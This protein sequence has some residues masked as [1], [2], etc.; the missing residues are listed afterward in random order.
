M[1]L[2]VLHSVT[3]R[4]SSARH[5][6][7][8]LDE[9]SL[10]I[11]QGELVA[12]WGV[13]RSGRSTLLRVAAGIEPPDEGVVTFAGRE[14]GSRGGAVLG[15]QVGYVNTNF[16][17]TQGGSV[18]DHVA[19]GLMASGLSLDQARSR[20][21]RALDRVGVANCADLDP[22]TLDPAEQVRVGLARALVFT[23]RLLLVDDPANGVGVLQRESILALVRSIADEGIAVLMTV[24]EVVTIADRVLTIDDG[25][26]RG[27]VAPEGARVLQLR[28]AH[29][30]P[31]A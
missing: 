28:P 1:P 9:V 7:I 26:L 4:Y 8:A 18:V 16:I 21:F 14:L 27:D 10:D 24:G 3:K 31:S 5:E 22:S 15:S 19:I 13:R 11:E 23:P 20:A 6:H 29:A 2:L 12:V 25:E 30:R 17:A